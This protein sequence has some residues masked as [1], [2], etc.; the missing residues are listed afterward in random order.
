MGSPLIEGTRQSVKE[1]RS[2]TP[3]AAATAGVLDAAYCFLRRPQ[4]YPANIAST[5]RVGDDHQT[6]QGVR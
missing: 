5:W 2:L 3:A 6:L 1:L 4:A